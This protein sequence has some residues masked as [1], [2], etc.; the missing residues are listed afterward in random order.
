VK[1]KPKTSN[2]IKYQFILHTLLS[3]FILNMREKNGKEKSYIK[4]GPIKVP[5]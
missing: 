5:C 1:I 2:A 4:K 3:L